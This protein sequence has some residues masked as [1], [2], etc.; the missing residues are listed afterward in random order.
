MRELDLSAL[1]TPAGNWGLLVDEGMSPEDAYD[2]IAE[3]AAAP[4][5]QTVLDH[6]RTRPEGRE[7]LQ[8]ARSYW[9]KAGL[10]CPWDRVLDLGPVS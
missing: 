10:P 8:V 9:D 7:I 4:E 5:F 3:C 1:M 6:Y 2:W